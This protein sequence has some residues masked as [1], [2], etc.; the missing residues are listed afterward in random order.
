M[1]R[2]S[3]KQRWLLG[4]ITCI[5]AIGGFLFGYDTGVISGAILYIKQEYAVTVIQEELIISMVSLGAIFG[6]ILGGPLCDKVGRKKIVLSSSLIFIVSAIGLSFSG[7]VNEIITWRFLVGFA[8]GVSSATAPLYIAELSPRHIRGALVTV[9]QLF[10]TIGILG[11]YLIGFLFVESQ[12]WRIMFAL[13]GI[14][15][16]IQFLVM[17]FFPESPRYLTNIGEKTKA[18]NILKKYRATEEDAA[19]EISHIEKIRK[20]KK[21]HWSELFSK[22]VRPALLAGVGVT[23]IQQIT[24][25]N[26]IIYYAPT[27]FKFAGIGSDKAA[28]LATTWVGTINVLMTFVAIYLLDK[29]GRKPLLLFGLGGM[30]LSL[31][32]L[33]I[34]FHQTVSKELIGIIAL[35]CLFTYIASF[36]FSLGPIGWLLNSEI[37]PLHIRGKA[38]GVATCANWVSNFIV[39]AT[40]LNLINLLGKSGT[41]WLYGI[42]GFLGLFFIW[43][44]VPE[45]KGKSLEEIEEYWK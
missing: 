25:I 44:R 42:I 12:S 45:T 7:S 9:N 6:A 14:P 37:Y 22:S 21:A 36:A 28:L 20:K 15:A 33:G 2:E 27:I 26:T 24:G 4:I 39:T 23:I 16:A 1:A 31:I 18:F 13:A 38:M 34:G 30:A 10:I 19:L 43:L 5:A 11:S 41:F 40:F 29:V 8:I 32:I 17:V 35:I 3:I